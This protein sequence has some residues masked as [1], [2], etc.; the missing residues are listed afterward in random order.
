[1][2]VRVSNWWLMGAGLALVALGAVVA[3]AQFLTPSLNAV[4]W[5]PLNLGIGLMA[6]AVK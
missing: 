5:V 4:W 1:L 3:G 2:G 6:V